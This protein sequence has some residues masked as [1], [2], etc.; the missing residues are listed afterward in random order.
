MKYLINWF[1]NKKKNKY[2][3]IETAFITV[4]TALVL[5]VFLFAVFVF[6][7]FFKIIE[8][9]EVFHEAACFVANEL[10][11]YG[12]S[13]LELIAEPEQK[14]NEKE[15]K[16]YNK[17][18]NKEE[19]SKEEINKEEFNN[20]KELNNKE[21]FNNKE[22]LIEE[23]FSRFP[24]KEELIS[25]VVEAEIIKQWVLSE[26]SIKEVWKGWIV[27]GIHGISFLGS[28]ILKEDQVII[29]IKYMIQFS[30]FGSIL[31]PIPVKQSI[32]I[33]SFTGYM[34]KLN[35]NNINKEEQTEEIVYITENGSVYHIN[36]D[37]SYIKLVIQNISIHDIL[38]KR[39][40]NGGKYYPCKQC[41]P[42]KQEKGIVYIT[43]Y[44]TNYH[45]TLSCS[46]LKRTV[47]EIKLSE[48]KDRRLCSKCK[49][50][51]KEE[52]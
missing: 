49:K 52:T 24:T 6:L 28:K 38:E 15:S 4:E 39:N 9:E 45:S 41:K 30:V 10:S 19:I 16:D 31:P 1:R 8:I 40:E 44:G 13:Q 37:C 3:S 21:E 7:S 25:D 18:I 51:K 20:K 17:E 29:N 36:R 50:S 42:D 14:Y 46:A 5:P 35:N 43:N 22:E 47:I 32:V 23:L 2:T 34:P 11:L 12:F 26:L 33:K 27:G 48:I